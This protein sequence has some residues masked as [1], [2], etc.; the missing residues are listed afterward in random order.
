[1]FIEELDKI[2]EDYDL[3]L[4]YAYKICDCEIEKY[5]LLNDTYL[6]LHDGLLKYP[7]RKLSKRFIFLT[8][9]S[10]FIDKLRK[11]TKW[12]Y[13][14]LDSIRELEQDKF[15]EDRLTSRTK[16]N[17]ALSQLKFVDREI[18]LRTEEKSLRIVAKQLQCNHVTIF[19]RKKEA[20]IKLK[21]KWQNGKQ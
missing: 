6:K 12:N 21:K 4:G 19:N 18:L 16:L 20:L 10:V 15:T 17:E 2:T 8:M 3:Y 9:R 11:E 1:M 5:D 14:D 13:T 7:N